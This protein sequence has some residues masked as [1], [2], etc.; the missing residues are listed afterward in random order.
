MK[1][2]NSC[3]CSTCTTAILVLLVFL[4]SNFSYTKAFESQ[5]QLPTSRPSGKRI[6][7]SRVINVNQFGAKGNGVDDDTEAFSNAW[8]LACSLSPRATIVIP[9]GNIYLVQ[10]IDFIGPC[11]AKVTLRILGTIVAPKDPDAWYGLNTQKWLYFH[12]VKH[13]TVEGEGTIN[14]KGEEWWARS[15]KVNASNPCHHAPTAVRFHRCMDL[16]VRGIKVVDSQQMHMSFY[17]CTRVKVSKIEVIAP[18]ASPNTDGIHI[19]SSTKVAIRN[20]VIKTGDDC[21]SIVSNSSRILISDVACG[22][23]HGISIGSLGKGDSWTEVNNVRVDGAFLANTENGV[24]IKT[25]QGGSGFAANI[26]FQNV[27]ME[28]VSNPI[29][30]DQYYCDSPLPCPN[31]TSAVQVDDISF[32]HIRGTSASEAAVTFNC[33]DTFPCRAL[34]LEDIQLVSYIGA[35]RSVCWEAQGSTSGLVSPPPCLS[36]DDSFIEQKISSTSIHSG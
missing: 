20:S 11:R 17:G 7:A 30:I 27:L 23:G 10:P 8:K 2:S 32:K 1:S 28:N 5:L 4:L 19:S 25:W 22:P 13:L 15:C 21:V 12:G 31:Q 14:G 36:T 33:S 3:S 35:T 24:R 18:A 34:Y 26:T 16:K 6:R 9:N 29:I